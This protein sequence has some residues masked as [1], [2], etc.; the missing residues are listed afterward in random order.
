MINL[1][2]IQSRLDRGQFAISDV[3]I[4]LGEINTQGLSADPTALDRINKGY[5]TI[6]DIYA[7]FAP[8]EAKY[9]TLYGRQTSAQKKAADIAAQQAAIVAAQ[10]A[11]QAASAAQAASE[12]AQQQA[13]QTTAAQA[14]SAHEA[15]VQAQAALD[16]F[17]ANQAA[18]AAIIAANHDKAQRLQDVLNG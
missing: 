15:T 3:Q 16:R 2:D 14:Q 17:N 12:S 1:D 11:R 5:R 10:A 4:L 9:F 13:W 7:L 8:V 18:T 6:S